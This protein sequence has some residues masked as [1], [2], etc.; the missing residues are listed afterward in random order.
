M[1]PI[2]ETRFGKPNLVEI[3]LLLNHQK[4]LEKWTFKLESR[5]P[6]KDFKT[7]VVT[8]WMV[9]SQCTTFQLSTI[10]MYNKGF[11]WPLNETCNI[12]LEM[13]LQRLQL[14]LCEFL[15]WNPYEG[16]LILQS[17]MIHNLI[18]K[19][20]LGLPFWNLENLCNFNVVLSTI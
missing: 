19:K 10:K 7:Q 6:F 12:T 13:S 9:G 5:F 11:K 2:F 15:N 17:K 14:F 16:V 1:F 18:I 8:E 20:K 3:E 4:G